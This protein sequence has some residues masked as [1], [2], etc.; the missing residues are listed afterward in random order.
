VSGRSE[1][2]KDAKITKPEITKKSEVNSRRLLFSTKSKARQSKTKK[3]RLV[4]SVA[5]V[6][7][8]L[9]AGR[10]SSVVGATAAVYLA[11]TNLYCTMCLAFP[12][13]RP[14][15]QEDGGEGGHHP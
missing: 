10:Y 4:M 11:A 7:G 8:R 13:S 3:A 9:K 1:H 5:S 6:L 14:V 12:S 15:Q 2:S